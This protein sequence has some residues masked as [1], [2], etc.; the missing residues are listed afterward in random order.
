MT[1]HML[2]QLTYANDP[3]LE[4]RPSRAIPPLPNDRSMSL[5]LSRQNPRT[6][7]MT[8]QTSRT[9]AGSHGSSTNANSSGTPRRRI[10]VACGRCRKR[11][12]RCS[13]D[14]GDNTGCGNCKAA[15][16]TQG[17]CVF[18]R[19]SSAAIDLHPHPYSSSSS[20]SS[21]S[22]SLALGH[23]HSNMPSSAL[24]HHHGLNSQHLMGQHSMRHHTMNP[25]GMPSDVMSL[26]SVYHQDTMG[27]TGGPDGTGLL[28]GGGMGLSS[29]RGSY[30]G[31]M[32][33]GT[34]GAS[35]LPGGDL[36]NGN[37]PQFLQPEITTASSLMSGQQGQWSPLTSSGRQGNPGLYLD[38]DPNYMPA[39][40]TRMQSHTSLDGYNTIFPA[41]N[42]LSSSLPEGVSPRTTLADR[43]TLPS[44]FRTQASENIS[45]RSNSTNDLSTANYSTQSIQPPTV[46]RGYSSWAGE[47]GFTTTSASSSNLTI[48]TTKTSTVNISPPLL[49]LSP[50]VSQSTQSTIPTALPLPP[51]LTSYSTNSSPIFPLSSSNSSL[52]PS[53][54]HSSSILS[55]SF[56]SFASQTLQSHSQQPKSVRSDSESS[57]SGANTSGTSG[58]SGTSTG[59]GGSGG[60]GGSACTAGG[61]GAGPSGAKMNTPAPTMR[62]NSASSSAYSPTYSRSSVGGHQGF[63]AGLFAAHMAD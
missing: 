1:R 56:D 8:R 22:S 61:T 29:H 2:N 31:D 17:T 51:A 27:N 39:P 54:P 7:P 18:L 37:Y 59:A 33:S 16:V 63:V 21:S 53:G 5:S 24:H 13:G 3:A 20:A 40:S 50:T 43:V 23:P 44:P 58:S 9:G 52:L 10:Q 48:P 57:S 47:P 19:V 25:T 4:Y 34:S 38:Q 41:L 14:P 12:I 46:G 6:D 42:S 60:S 28:L 45:L 11:K 26:K 35:V 62:T 15:S 30:E 49:Y 32:S 36:Y 55:S